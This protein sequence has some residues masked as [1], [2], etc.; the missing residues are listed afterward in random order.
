MRNNVIFSTEKEGFLKWKVIFHH[1]A[2]RL[3][4]KSKIKM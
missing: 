3:F 2:V 4:S 1:G